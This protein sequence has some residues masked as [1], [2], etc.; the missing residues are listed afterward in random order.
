MPTTVEVDDETNQRLERLE[1]SKKGNVKKA[2]AA[3]EKVTRGVDITTSISPSTRAELKEEMPV[4]G[5]TT[6]ITIYIEPGSEDLVR[7]RLQREDGTHIFPVKG[8]WVDYEIQKTIPFE[9]PVEKGEEL[10]VIVEN[11]DTQNAH[12]A[13]FDVVVRGVPRKL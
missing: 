3:M 9:I 7:I 5:R 12:T 6:H 13:G 4:T 1:G 8:D 11:K 10:H 2:V